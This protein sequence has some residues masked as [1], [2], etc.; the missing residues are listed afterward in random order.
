MTTR[1]S[2]RP[3]PAYRYIPGRQPHPTRDPDGHSYG[4]EPVELE[5]FD[6]ADWHNCDEYLYAID[7]LN[8]GYWW[9]A[10]ESLEAIW[11]AAGQRTT[12]VGRFVQGLLQIGVGTLKQH[13][14]L[15]GGARRLW[16]SGLDKISVR[17]P[18]YL[19]LDTRTLQ[20]AVRELINGERDTLP[21]LVLHFDQCND[22]D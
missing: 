13:Q 21:E 4:S 2:R 11:L 16:Q 19:G 5:Q 22:R 8:H 12:Q 15:E 9:E 7:L 20:Q 14:E 6:P 10:H 17:E 3:F 18:I 1:Y